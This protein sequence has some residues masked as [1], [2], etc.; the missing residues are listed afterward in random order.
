MCHR[1]VWS[2]LKLIVQFLVASVAFGLHY[3]MLLANGYCM[4][5]THRHRQ[6]YLCLGKKKSDVNLR[7]GSLY[8]H[9]PLTDP[10]VKM[11]FTR[12]KMHVPRSGSQFHLERWPRFARSSNIK[13]GHAAQAP[14]GVTP[15]HQLCGGKCKLRDA[16]YCIRFLA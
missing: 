13:R 6:S 9:L 4:I 8:M 16:R 12:L 10:I 15:S 7:A 2:A 5:C 3:L 11:S 1:F 14:E